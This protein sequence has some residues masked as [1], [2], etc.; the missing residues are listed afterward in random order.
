MLCKDLEV[1]D[2]D[3][4][5]MGLPVVGGLWLCTWHHNFQILIS[6][7]N[8]R[9]VIIISTLD[10]L[11]QLKVVLKLHLVVGILSRSPMSTCMDLVV[12]HAIVFCSLKLN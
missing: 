3:Y 2:K 6:L 10:W 1:C 5:R 7:Y 11:S 4:N 8:Y 9:I 12:I